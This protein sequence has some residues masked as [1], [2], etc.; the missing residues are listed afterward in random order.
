MRPFITRLSIVIFVFTTILFLVGMGMEYFLYRNTRELFYTRQS[1][2]HLYHR[3]KPDVLFIGNSRMAAHVDMPK[4][5]EKFKMP[6][7]LLGQDARNSKVLWYKF[8]TFISRNRNPKCIVLQFDPFFLRR[9]NMT[10]ATFFAKE[11]Y[12]SYLF[13]NSLHINHLFE[14]EKGFYWYETFVPLVRYIHYPL[15]FSFHWHKKFSDPYAKPYNAGSWLIQYDSTSRL[16]NLD[17][18]SADAIDDFSMS[19]TNDFQYID[20]FIHY[21]KQH[22]I[23]L[24]LVYPPQSPASYNRYASLNIQRMH[25]YL[26]QYPNIPFRDFNTVGID[27]DSLYHNHLHLNHLGAQVYTQALIHYLDSLNIFEH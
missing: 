22:Q 12:L 18:M 25:A 27:A 1:D 13:F 5:I 6:M 21:C 8:K 2:W 9:R 23:N 14:Q 20:S 7:Y 10:Q 24:A 15:M 26:K 19:E 17:T 3:I 4:V 11:N 16:A